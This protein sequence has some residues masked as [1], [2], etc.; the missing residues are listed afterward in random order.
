M[1]LKTFNSVPCSEIKI[2]I[3]IDDCNV[4][5]DGNADKNIHMKEFKSTNPYAP[6]PLS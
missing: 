2:E 3:K 4:N 1:N 6:A 5:N